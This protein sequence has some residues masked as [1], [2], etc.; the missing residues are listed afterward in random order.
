MKFKARQISVILLAV[1]LILSVGRVCGAVTAVSLVGSGTEK[2]NDARYAD[3]ESMVLRTTSGGQIFTVSAVNYGDDALSLTR[4][5][6]IDASKPWNRGKEGALLQQGFAPSS[7][8]STTHTFSPT[9]GA[10]VQQTDASYLSVK[11]DK[12][13]ATMFASIKLDLIASTINMAS[14]AWAGTSADNFTNPFTATRGGLSAQG[15]AYS[16]TFSNLNYVGDAPLELRF[17][18]LQG[19]DAAQLNGLQLQ[20]NLTPIPEAQTMIALGMGA[21]MCFLRRRRRPPSSGEF[22]EVK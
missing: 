2:L 11:I 13:A 18:G 22:S 7:V 15:R 19:A 10:P 3:G 4:W 9:A 8:G 6:L 20:V 17:Y 16:W 5:G 12:S 21:S 1:A 14:T